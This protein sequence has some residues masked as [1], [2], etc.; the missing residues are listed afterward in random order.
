MPCP[1]N[2]PIQYG[3][4]VLERQIT[5]FPESARG[6]YILILRLPTPVVITVGKFGTFLFAA[7]WYAYVG[8]AFGA[9][10]LRGRLK[11]HLNPQHRLHWHIDYLA[12]AAAIEEIWYLASETGY[13]H[14]WAKL[15]T[16]L[17]YATL[18][19]KRFGASD[20][21]CPA[22]LFHFPIRPSF[23]QFQVLTL[24]QGDVRCWDVTPSNGGL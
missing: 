17:P 12:Q 10:G 4:W 18:P 6:T 20:C 19:V 8:S 5:L 2:S 7:E 9:G 23:S 16:T 15:L 3:T 11:H 24:D 14:R 1:Y 13:E 21:K 22:H